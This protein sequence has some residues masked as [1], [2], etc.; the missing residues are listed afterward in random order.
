MN[1]SY[2][3]IFPFSHHRLISYQIILLLPPRTH[4]CL[5]LHCPHPP[6]IGSF[7]LWKYYPL[8]NALLKFYLF[9]NALLN[10]FPKPPSQPLHCWR[11]CNLYNSSFCI[12]LSCP[13]ECKPMG[14]GQDSGW[15]IFRHFTLQCYVLNCLV[16]NKHFMNWTNSYHD[17]SSK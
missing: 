1:T 12:W 15:Y 8:S 6:E 17:K 9:H 16:P 10:L 14:M 2:H 13:P 7:N 3:T 5:C 11:S 4:P